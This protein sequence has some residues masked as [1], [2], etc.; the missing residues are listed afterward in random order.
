MVHF[1]PTIS[2]SGFLLKGNKMLTSWCGSN[3]DPWFKYG[4]Y[5]CDQKEYAIIKSNL[6]GWHFCHILFT[7]YAVFKY[8]DFSFDLRL[9]FKHEI[10]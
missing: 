7:T 6:M 2:E 8:S 1:L 3:W 9:A 5:Q 4:C 10:F